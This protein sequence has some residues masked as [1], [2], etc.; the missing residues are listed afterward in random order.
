MTVFPK[1][2]KGGLRILRVAQDFY[3]LSGLKND[4]P[5]NAVRRLC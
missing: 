5:V 1:G 2:P 4:S 3:G